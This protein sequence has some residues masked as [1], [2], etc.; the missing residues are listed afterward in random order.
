MHNL[1]LLGFRCFVAAAVLLLHAA[2]L[3]L[4]H[5]EG[6]TFGSSIGSGSTSGCG[7][8]PFLSRRSSMDDPRYILIRCLFPHA[9]V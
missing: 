9:I 4:L 5:T 7:V 2:L 8:I 1:K 3:L 6:S